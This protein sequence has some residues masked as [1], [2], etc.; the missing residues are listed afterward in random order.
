M[1]IKGKV[2]HIIAQVEI[3][4][5]HVC[6]FNR[7]QAFLLNFPTFLREKDGE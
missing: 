5:T 2:D 1:T 3:F 7:K 6:V 4:D